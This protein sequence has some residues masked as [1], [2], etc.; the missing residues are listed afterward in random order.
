M[1]DY[2]KIVK[3]FAIMLV[4]SVK[5]NSAPT[6]TDCDEY[7][8][9]IP[10][11]QYQSVLHQLKA[12]LVAARYGETL[13]KDKMVNLIRQL[14]QAHSQ[15]ALSV[16][17]SNNKGTTEEIKSI[18]QSA[19]ELLNRVEIMRTVRYQSNSLASQ[20]TNV[21]SL[22]L[23]LIDVLLENDGQSYLDAIVVIGIQLKN[24]ERWKLDLTKLYQYHLSAEQPE[25]DD[26]LIT[27]HL[28]NDLA[29]FK[30]IAT[31]FKVGD[32]NRG[33][34]ALKNKYAAHYVNQ[35]LAGFEQLE[36]EY[37]ELLKTLDDLKI[38]NKLILRHTALV[39]KEL[40]A[41]TW[42]LN[43]EHYSCRVL[44]KPVF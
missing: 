10:L 28:K 35:I 38:A 18:V 17:P 23:T 37:H 20:L 5:A 36:T 9:V 29:G 12:T 39:N 21:E 30:T 15:Y 27:S 41:I 8:K 24:I 44:I 16:N 40:K 33:I 7:A 1:F 25:F 32:I 14:E 3:L 31:S 26:Q 19:D 22:Y 42:I 34:Q 11:L 43:R 6:F 2:S 13:A 4:I